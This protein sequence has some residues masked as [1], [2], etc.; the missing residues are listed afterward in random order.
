MV[1]WMLESETT[2]SLTVGEP[3]QYWVGTTPK[4]FT[5]FTKE[6]PTNIEYVDRRAVSER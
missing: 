6:Y 2:S 5:E 3:N 1:K 4:G